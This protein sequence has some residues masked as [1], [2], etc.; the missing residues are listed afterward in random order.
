[1]NQIDVSDRMR[2]STASNRRNLENLVTT[3]MSS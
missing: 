1:M 2:T 3:I